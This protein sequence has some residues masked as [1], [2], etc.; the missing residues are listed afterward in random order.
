MHNRVRPDRSVRRVVPAVIAALAL[1]LTAPGAVAA[2]PLAGAARLPDVPAPPA[3][4]P[5]PAPTPM[6]PA[7][8]AAPGPGAADTFALRSPLCE[9]AR[10][11]S[12]PA[13]QQRA[14]RR[15]G[16]PL[17]GAPTANYA[18]DINWDPPVT[19][20][21]EVAV[22]AIYKVLNMLW[23]GLLYCL[24]G[25]LTLLDWAFSLNPFAPSGAGGS[26]MAGLG[27]ALERF[28]GVIDAGFLSALVVGV[29]IWGMW[30]GLVRRDTPR[31]I[32]GLCL[33]VL[34]VLCALA[35][36]HR[37][38]ATAGTVARLSNQVAMGLLAAPSRGLDAAPTRSYAEAMHDLFDDVV[39]APWC[40]L[41]FRTQR[42]CGGRAE[43]GA[44]AHMLAAQDDDK[45]A[46]LALVQRVADEADRRGLDEAARKRLL[47]E[48]L[49]AH[50]GIPSGPSGAS[51]AELWLSL[52]PDSDARRALYAYYG[53]KDAG[54]VGVLGVNVLNT[55]LG[56]SKGRNPDEVAVQGAAGG[57]TRLPLLVIIA[58][59]VLGALLFLGWIALRL[60]GQAA[61]GFVLL[62]LAPLALLLVT[63]G[64]SGRQAFARWGVGLLGALVSKVIYAALLGVA[65]LAARLLA[66]GAD[67]AN[68]LLTWLLQSAFWWT[69]FVR[70]E[71][72]IGVLSAVPT[73]DSASPAVRL[74]G[75]L[76]AQRLASSVTGA[77]GDRR[78]DVRGHLLRTRSA[79]SDAIREGARER[80]TERAERQH[81]HERQGAEQVLAR[82]GELREA[83]DG[84][85]FAPG[86]DGT[87]ADRGSGVTEPAPAGVVA[88]G[89]EGPTA[90]QPTSVVQA[91]QLGAAR[92]ALAP[93]VER[94][95][96]EL[97][98]SR[99]G[100]ASAR[101]VERGVP[102][103]RL[104]QELDLPATDPAHAW[105]V[106]RTRDELIRL[107]EEDPGAHA[108]Q[109]RTIAAQLAEDRSLMRA[110]PSD[111]RTPPQPTVE[112]AAAR[113][114]DPARLE[115][116]RRERARR[117]RHARDTR[118]YLY[119]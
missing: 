16:S 90:S 19:Q 97:A 2:A 8:V 87:S 115:E 45:A 38:E 30:R 98:T 64:D 59:G 109:V 119:R 49:L 69:L 6:M 84:L 118:R 110:L 4:S 74:A 17:S 29:G 99:P 14:C 112:R 107:R 33:S 88:A 114:L 44:V 5:T 108:A 31:A 55:S 75:V 71:Q 103:E 77:A 113:V 35:V 62:L 93:A 26:P 40:A 51:R 47:G 11:L 52:A 78:D 86:R 81:S 83:L 102:L 76:S 104:R 117:L 91:E 37:P 1:A 92:A 42:F 28:F 58:L 116:L 13:A 65:V 111:P 32:G 10:R 54:K 96:S 95:R 24:R 27:R 94:A 22:K 61:L 46:V 53:G 80:L 7:P 106:G 57:L 63:F 82:D 18:F 23:L 9:P 34:M 60:L 101:E 68:W 21:A 50:R 36:I 20:P 48:A 105:R 56:D 79:R 12:L 39:R 73:F 43:R 89:E 72:L 85:A 100:P 66:Q 15:T 70:R 67:S 25:A 41:D 3:A